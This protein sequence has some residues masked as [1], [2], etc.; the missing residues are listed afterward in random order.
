MMPDNTTGPPQAWRSCD[1]I[2]A[3]WID[4]TRD[5]FG[6]ICRH[7]SPPNELCHDGPGAR[8]VLTSSSS[9]ATNRILPGVCPRYLNLNVEPLELFLSARFPL[10]SRLH[11]A[12]QRTF[13]DHDQF[14]TFSICLLR[15][16]VAALKYGELPLYLRKAL[17]TS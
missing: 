1:L 17:A 5:T 12:S 4:Q 7:A 9:P 3:N 2:I 15:F 13:S 10:T 14:S 11:T 8:H 6:M 16:V